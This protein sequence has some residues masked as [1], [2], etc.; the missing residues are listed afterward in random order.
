MTT[1]YILNTNDKARD[2]LS[3]QHGLYAQSS[4]T[5]IEEA[6]IKPGMSGLEI[7]CGSGVMTLELARRIG[8]NGFLLAIDLSQEQLDHVQS[9]TNQDNRIR[10]KLWDV[11]H[12]SDL[13]EQYDFIY[14]RMVLH[15]VA[16]AHSVIVQMSRCLKP[17]GM[18]ICEEPSLFDS[19]FCYPASSAYNQYTQWVRGCFLT[20]K[21]DLEIAYRL[22]QEFSSCGLAVT[23][24][25]LFQPILRS[26]E[27]KMIYAM[28]LDDLTPQL[29]SLGIASRQEISELS[30]KLHELAHST[31]TMT[32]MRMHKVIARSK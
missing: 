26:T 27:E 22:E 18:I 13:G 9:I 11:N 1:P 28:G 10:F 16:D 7:G 15:H 25:S 4:K 30:H 6:G 5:L 20:N 19:T 24:H 2:R 3:L 8:L 23:E 14:C 32:W 29:L 12:L 21:R 17:G 31:N